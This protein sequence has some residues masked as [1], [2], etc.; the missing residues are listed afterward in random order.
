MGER[1]QMMKS[2]ELSK[3]RG[4]I[5]I[6]HLLPPAKRDP[7]VGKLALEARR[8]RVADAGAEQK[9]PRL[10]V[11]SAQGNR[12]VRSKRSGRAHRLGDQF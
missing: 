8:G 7:K 1:M 12:S 4:L 11:Q 2:V 3:L 6:C 9:K 10:L 5:L